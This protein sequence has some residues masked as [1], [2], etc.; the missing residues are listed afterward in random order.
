M[1][2]AAT[3][4]K[5]SLFMAHIFDNIVRIQQCMFCEKYMGNYSWQT[6]NTNEIYCTSNEQKRIVYIKLITFRF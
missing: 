3:M 2:F 5:W 1:P 4:L 6:M